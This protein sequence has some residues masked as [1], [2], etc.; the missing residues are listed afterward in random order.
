MKIENN[1]LKHYLKN[2]Y[3]NGGDSHLDIDEHFGVE[4][5]GRMTKMKLSRMELTENGPTVLYDSIEKLRS[6]VQKK[7]NEK[8]SSLESLNKLLEQKRNK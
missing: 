8:N 4:E 5:M 3:F 1:I 7:K 6:A 2:A